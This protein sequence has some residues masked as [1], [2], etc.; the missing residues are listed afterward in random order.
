[1]KKATLKNSWALGSPA[2]SGNTARMMGTA[3]RRPT[4][5]MKA[6]SRSWKARKGNNPRK[7]DSGRARTII[8]RARPRAGRM[9]GNS[10]WGVTSRPR[11]RN[12]P[13]CASQVRPSSI[14]RMPWRERIGRLPRNRPKR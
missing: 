9:M 8:H 13:I 5:A 14:C 3:P 4:Q 1:M 12:M 2:I 7:T 6:F 11:T 10:S